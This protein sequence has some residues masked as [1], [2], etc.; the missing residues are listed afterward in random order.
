MRMGDWKSRFLG[1][2]VS[3]RYGSDFQARMLNWQLDVR[4]NS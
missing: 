1:D 4:V 2:M 3:V